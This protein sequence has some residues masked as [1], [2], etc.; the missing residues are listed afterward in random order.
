M[1]G[2]VVVDI[3]DVEKPD[4]K[5]TLSLGGGS[6][7]GID[8]VGNYAYIT[9]YGKGLAIVDI[10]DPL[11]PV[12]KATYYKAEAGKYKDIEVVGDYAYIASEDKDIV[13]IDVSDVNSVT[14]DDVWTK[15]LT[16]FSAARGI[17][18]AGAYAF[19]SGYGSG[20]SSYAVLA[21]VDISTPQAPFEEKVIVSNTGSRGHRIIVKGDYAYISD[22][23]DI[24][25]FALTD[26]TN[27]TWKSEVTNLEPEVYGME[28]VDD[29]LYAAGKGLVVVDISDPEALE[30]LGTSIYEGQLNDVKA[31]E[32]HPEANRNPEK[33][34]R[35]YPES[36][37]KN[38]EQTPILTW[39]GFEKDGETLEY[40]V[41]F[42]TT[43]TPDKVKSGLETAYYKP[44]TLDRGTK[45][46]WKVVVRD[47]KGNETTGDV[48]EFETRSDVSAEHVA[49]VSEDGY[50]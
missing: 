16:Y 40:D 8:V 30:S 13:V 25:S 19:V 44:A 3:R 28:I 22:Y 45:Y 36:R 31:I 17:D 47:S 39:N 37:S 34:E 49:A 38:I 20:S 46:Y 35:E 12:L 11:K 33:P 50:L 26:L 42:G 15:S 29:T 1:V 48:W 32:W 5:A 9:V 41:Y 2:L 14:D 43:S 23:R 6:A 10:S 21:V 27:P 4:E 24:N 18:V 7:N